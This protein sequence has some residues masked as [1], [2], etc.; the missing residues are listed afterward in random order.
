MKALLFTISVVIVVAVL[1]AVV[2]VSV[3]V[4]AGIAVVLLFLSTYYTL[5]AKDKI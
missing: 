3:W 5:Q 1:I 4:M 2:Y